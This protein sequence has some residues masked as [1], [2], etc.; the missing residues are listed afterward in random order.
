[1]RCIYI[2]IKTPAKDQ[3]SKLR[4]E[5]ATAGCCFVFT[6][7]GFKVILSTQQI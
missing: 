5:R 6:Q 4:R 7:A 3:A 1:M 2:Y